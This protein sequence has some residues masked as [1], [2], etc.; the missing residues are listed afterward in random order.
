MGQHQR[1]PAGLGQLG[2]QP[3]DDQRLAGAGRHDAQGS[4]GRPP[5]PRPEPRD[6]LVGRDAGS[7]WKDVP[8][9][10]Q[11]R[12]V[13][14]ARRYRGLGC[15]AWKDAGVGGGGDTEGGAP[16]CVGVLDGCWTVQHAGPSRDD[17]G[18]MLIL[19][20]SLIYKEKCYLVVYVC[21][22]SRETPMLD[23]PTRPTCPTSHSG[24][25][26]PARQARSP[27]GKIQP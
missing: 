3:G 8:G 6:S 4:T 20:K 26:R 10:P 15:A 7:G 18:S 25:G 23:R 24:T 19:A 12:P 11:K 13:R 22:R 16:R 14:R 17:F 21:K 9:R 1:P 2:H 5:P 27:S